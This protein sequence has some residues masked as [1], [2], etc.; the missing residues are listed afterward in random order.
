VM[1]NSIYMCAACHHNSA[2]PKAVKIVLFR[3]WTGR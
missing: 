3:F 1:A 2:K